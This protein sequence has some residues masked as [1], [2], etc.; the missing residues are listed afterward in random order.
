MLNALGLAVAEHACSRATRDIK[1]RKEN[2]RLNASSSCRL[3]ALNGNSVAYR[4]LL[5]ARDDG[6]RE[7]LAC[8]PR[9]HLSHLPHEIVRGAA[10]RRRDT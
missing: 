6:N 7:M 5:W 9:W 10:K 3:L 8:A 2:M 4:R 1:W